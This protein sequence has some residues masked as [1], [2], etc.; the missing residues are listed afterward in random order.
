M[1]DLPLE[2][3]IKSCGFGGA[4]FPLA[5]GGC[6]NWAASL[7]C[8]AARLRLRRLRQL[9]PKRRRPRRGAPTSTGGGSARLSL[10]LRRRASRRLSLLR[11]SASW[12]LSLLRRSASRLLHLTPVGGAP[13]LRTA[14]PSGARQGPPAPAARPLTSISRSP[15]GES[16]SACSA[17]GGFVGRLCFCSRLVRP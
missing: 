13:C 7:G 15:A 17:E 4:G 8:A 11:R 6:W 14:R 2:K 12:R 5:S 9:E 16:P 3:K 10:S 1:P